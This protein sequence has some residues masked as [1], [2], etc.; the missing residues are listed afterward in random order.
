[1][2]ILTFDIEDWFHI[3]DNTSTKTEQEWALYDSRL[4]DNMERIYNLLEIENL[5]ATFFCLGW[6]AKKNPN[7]IR[8]IYDLGFEIGSHSNMHQL[9]YEQDK[10]RFRHDLENSIK[11]IEDITGEKVK[12]YRAPG[13]SII[14]DNRWAFE[15]LVEN[16]IE[17]DC[18]IFP[19]KRAH[20]GFENVNIDRPSFVEFNGVRLKVFPINLYKFL[21]KNIVFS[22]GGYFRVLPYWI[23]KTLIIRSD[24]VMCYFHPRDFDPE[25]P[26]IQELSWIRKFRS[27]YGLSGAYYKLQ[28]MV[29]NFDFIDLRE[30]DK[31]VDWD[32]APV[33]QLDTIW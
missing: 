18:S 1:M 23:I 28:K 4:L 21:G 26:V 32:R 11:A 29:Q 22:G 8:K 15:V 9:A 30:A 2:Y 31:M 25:Q 3:L 20:G 19:A 33:V 17:I 14:K 7:I 27:Y 13:F 16:G 24:Y 6:I 10:N 5:K 12:A